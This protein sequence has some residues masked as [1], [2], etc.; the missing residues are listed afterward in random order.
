M[1]RHETAL[2]ATAT[3]CA[4]SS[5]KKYR[6][7]VSVVVNRCCCPGQ[8]QQPQQQQSLATNKC[9]KGTEAELGLTRSRSPSLRRG[10]RAQNFLAPGRAART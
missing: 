2:P 9:V 10:P 7:K 4:G 3:T 6:Q 5:T 8:Q 1:T